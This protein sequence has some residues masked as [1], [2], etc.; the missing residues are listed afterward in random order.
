VPTRTQAIHPSARF[1]KPNLSLLHRSLTRVGKTWGGGV[2][3]RPREF[4][5]AVTL[6]EGELTM[7]TLFGTAL[8]LIVLAVTPLSGQAEP[9]PAGTAKTLLEIVTALEKTYDPIVEVSFDDGAWEVEAFKGDVAYELAVDPVSGAVVSEFRDFGEVKPPAGSQRLSKIIS[10]LTQSGYSE[11]NEISFER[12]NWEVE[13][14][15]DNQK[16]ELHIDP[17]SGAIASDRVDD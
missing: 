14:V 9:R 11:I 5:A 13:A 4:A 10:Q 6:T 15:R 2:I 3:E 1:L 16:R 7:K 12:I 17:K 8:A